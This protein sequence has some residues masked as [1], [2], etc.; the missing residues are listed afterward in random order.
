MTYID[1]VCPLMIYCSRCIILLMEGLSMNYQP[2]Q[3][4]NQAK[5][6]SIGALVCGILGIVGGFI[7]IVQYFTFVLAIIGTVLGV[8]GRKMGGGSMATAGMVLGIIGIVLGAVGIVCTICVGAA[9]G[10]ALAGY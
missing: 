10:L 9:A 2:Q 6:I 7:P 1:R 8:K 4:P 5:N 3:D